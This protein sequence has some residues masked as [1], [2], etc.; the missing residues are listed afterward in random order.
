MSPARPSA[1]V[2]ALSVLPFVILAA[3]HWSYAPLITAGDYAQ[4]LLHADA[5]AHGRAYADIGY[6]YSPLAPFIGPR[7]QP[8]GLPLTILPI[9]A[10]GGVS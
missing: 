8:P 9:V 2:I 4:Y 10:V 5:L 7:V 6:I 1:T 3:L